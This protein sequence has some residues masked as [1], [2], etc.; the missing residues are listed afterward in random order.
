[1]ALLMS[2][3]QSF[4]VAS[5]LDDLFGDDSTPKPLLRAE[6]GTSGVSGDNACDEL[7]DELV[8]DECE[9][10]FR[11]SCNRIH[12]QQS[13][14]QQLSGDAANS[15]AYPVTAWIKTWPG[16]SDTQILT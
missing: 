13:I 14:V 15:G 2:S 11:M 5:A 8:E 7:N 9:S 12:L 3:L 10:P 1:M 4:A 6:A 16:K